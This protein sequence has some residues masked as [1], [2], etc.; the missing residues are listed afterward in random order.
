VPSRILRDTYATS[1]SVAA[2]EPGAQDRMPRYLLLAD[3]FGCFPVN[4]AVIAGRIFSLR[5]DMTPERVA[6]DLAEMERVGILETWTEGNKRYAHFPGWL[7][8]QRAPRA[9][10]KRKTPEPPAQ[11]REVPGS[12]GQICP[13]S[14]SQSQ[15]Q[16]SIA[17]AGKSS[18]PRPAGD[19]RHKAMIDLF[20]RLW[21][22]LRGG[23]YD[24]LPR[25][26]AAVKAFLKSHPDTLAEIERRMRLAFADKWFAQNGN[27]A[28]FASRW[29]NY[30]KVIAF[31][32]PAKRKSSRDYWDELRGCWILKDGTADFT[33]TTPPAEAK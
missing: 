7:R 17:V 6:A 21:G 30:D 10:A 22:E 27:L 3:D 15:S 32:Q 2:M 9:T 5:K 25:D 31:V 13:Q 23:R 18:A 29:S 1:E 19:P 14:Q 28:I 24:V 33:D 12:A 26:T 20:F 11:C 4:E 16:A 8:N